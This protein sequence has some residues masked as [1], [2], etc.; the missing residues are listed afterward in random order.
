MRSL[1]IFVLRR[2]LGKAGLLGGEIAPLL[3]N[4]LLHLSG[5]GS[6]SC[7][8]LL[9]YINTLLGG[10]KLGDQ[11][12]HMGTGSLGLQGTLFLGGIL[13]NGLGL[14]IAHLS[15]L[16]EST[17]S[18]GAQLSGL[19]GTSGDGS[20]L[21]DV[22][23]GN[24]ADLSGPLGALGEGGV[25]RGLISTLLIL[26]SGALNNIIFNIM[27]F[28]L[29]PALTL[30][31]GP[32]DLRALDVTILDKGSSANLDSLV[33]SN[34]LVIDE[35]VLSEVLLTFLLLLRLVVGHI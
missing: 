20:V 28:L 19:L 9:G 7:A 25:T 30:I 15:T 8:H 33:E 12:G 14:V 4:G 2:S 27:F 6:G 22:L 1:L 21:L 3:D 18:R 10:F 29:G 24:A 17:T 34:L 26:N 35:T 16:L 5:V 23:L 13:D 31:L 11:L 32:T